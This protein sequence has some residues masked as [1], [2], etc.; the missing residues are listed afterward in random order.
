MPKKLDIEPIKRWF[1]K[2]DYV[3][4]STHYVSA[5]TRLDYICP[6]GHEHSMSWNNFHQGKRCPTCAMGK[7]SSTQ[8]HDIAYIREQFEA[9][10]W[11]LKSEK[12]VNGYIKLDYI[13][14]KGHVGSICWTHFQRGVGCPTCSRR[15]K[16]TI[17]VVTDIF[18]KRGFVLK[19]TE[20]VNGH[21]ILDYICPNGHEHSTSLVNFQAGNGCPTCANIRMSGPGSSLWRG[22][23]SCDHYCDAWADKEYKMDIKQRDS[24]RCQNPYCFCNSGFADN[25]SIHHVDYNK[26]NCSP[27]NL[28]VLCRSCH[29]YSNHNRD[30]HTAWYQTIMNHKYGYT[31]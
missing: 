6:E 17:G 25:L 21:S 14:D 7:R 28:I 31:Y 19:S 30:W 9:R 27:S 8:S 4:K 5:H 12:Y 23:I 26:K 15:I 20:Y 10:N 16:P 3:L 24:Y 1:E 29:S 22:G 13:C 11:I 2:N 18:K